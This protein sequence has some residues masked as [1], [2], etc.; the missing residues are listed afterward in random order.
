[1]IF[2]KY[3]FTSKLII[4]YVLLT[5]IPMALMGAI[6]Y[7]Q[8]TRSIERQ[9][10]EYIPRILKQAGDNL[11]NQIQ[12]FVHLPDLVYNSS[13]VIG[14]LRKDSWQHQSDFLK[15][16]FSVES[17][18]TRAYL[19]GS[20]PD[21]TAV[22]IQSK[23]RLFH[24]SRRSFRDFDFK[25]EAIPYAQEFDFRGNVKILLPYEANLRFEG[26]PP[27]LM[28]VRQIKDFDNRKILGTMF[29]AVELGFMEDILRDIAGKETARLWIMN[30]D[31]RVVY[32]TEKDRIGTVY[33]AVRDFPVLNGTFK[34]VSPEPGEL[35]GV[36][37]SA[38]TGW[39]LVY[40]IPL[41]Q[42]TSETDRVRNATMLA[43]AVFVTV[44]AL[45]SVVLVW[46]FTRRSTGS[47]LP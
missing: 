44:T 15:D 3:R 19:S 10:G 42:L 13:E 8:Y 1:M 47:A 18:L 43:F 35:F 2:K 36:N 28:I 32:H 20:Y 7:S 27:Y 12:K 38:E 11:D 21:V 41:K 37:A 14:I 4:T 6:A 45:I 24:V 39:I 17:Y 26:N 30:R 22:F 5:V 40:N 46:R 23:N 16:K 31:G 33:E 29:V 34:S 25:Q 9:V